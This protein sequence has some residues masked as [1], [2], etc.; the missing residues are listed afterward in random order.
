MQKSSLATT[1]D[2]ACRRH[3]LGELPAAEKLFRQVLRADPFNVEAAYR[4]ASIYRSQ[5]R[6][7]DAL[8]QLVNVLRTQP[9][10]AEAHHAKG[11]IFASKGD[12]DEALESFRHAVTHKPSFPE[13]HFDRGVTFVRAKRINEA[14]AAF[15]QAILYRSDYPEALLQL[16][17]A[18][19]TQDKIDQAIDTYRSLLLLRPEDGDVYNSLG[20]LF[21]KIKRPGEAVKEFRKALAKDST[22]AGYHNNLGAA[23]AESG[24]PKEAIEHFE[25]AV[26]IN[27][28]HAEAH[29]SLGMTLLQLGDFERG[30][31]EYEWR[32]KC[33]G[34]TPRKLKSP[35]WDG[36]ALS[37]R[38]ILLYTEQGIGDNLQFIRYAQSV[39]A[40]GGVVLVECPRALVPLFQTCPDVAEVIAQ[41]TDLPEFNCHAP[42]LSLPLLLGT[43]LNTVP[44]HVPYLAAD[45]EQLNRLERELAPMNAFKVGIVWQGSK[46]NLQDHRRSIPLHFF[47]MLAQVPGVELFSLQKG[48]GVEQLAKIADQFRVIDLGSKLDSNGEAFV[49]TAA[50]VCKLDLVVTCC[51]A[52][53]HLAGALGRPVWVALSNPADWRWLLDR[54]DSPWYPTMRLFRQTDPENW[55]SV[56]RSI[57]EELIVVIGKQ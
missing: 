27:P 36:T 4:L 43:T 50:A 21:A 22:Q 42:L 3:S 24:N 20:L 12:L 39:R 30:W 26:R 15:Q 18:Y 7:P 52:I 2:D 49:G 16:A 55:P 25:A 57:R 53:A 37:G 19:E 31:Q 38:R 10:F 40:R 11:M 34:F 6:V 48:H 51:T 8:T 54:E 13:A 5:D 28:Q 35:Q 44:A 1:L 17:R 41:G 9:D 29:K 45:G 47:G 56:F 33:K 32:W 14:V 23:L 46:T